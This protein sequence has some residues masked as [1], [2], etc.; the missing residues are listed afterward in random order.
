MPSCVDRC[1]RM[2][3]FEARMSDFQHD[4]RTPLNAMMGFA[5]LMAM[6][7]LPDELTEQAEAIVASGRDMVRLL[8]QFIPSNAGDGGTADDRAA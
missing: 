7:D 5:Q 8:E 6:S 3:E 4:A 1:A 2:T